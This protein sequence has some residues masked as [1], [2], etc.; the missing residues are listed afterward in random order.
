MIYLP[1]PEA[2]N[3]MDI[4]ERTLRTRIAK[5]EVRFRAEPCNGGRR[6]EVAVEDHLER[7]Y[8]GLNN[9]LKEQ[10]NEMDVFNR[11]PEYKKNVVLEWEM[12]FTMTAGFKGVELKSFCKAYTPKSP[13]VKLT[14]KTYYRK[15][16][17]YIKHGQSALIPG[18]GS[19]GSGKITAGQYEYFKKLYLKEMGPTA[20]KCRL[21]TFGKFGTLDTSLNLSTFPSASAFLSKLRK[22][23]KQPAI[24]YARR[25]ELYYKRN[26]EYYISRDWTDIEAGAWLVSDHHQLDVLCI[27]QYGNKIRPWLTAWMD[28]RTNK[29]V[30]SW[31]H[32]EAPNSD[33]IFMTFAWAVEADGLPDGVYL[34]NGKD[35]RSLD[36]SGNPKRYKYWEE[37]NEHHARCLYNKFKVK[38]LF[39]REYNAQAKPIEPRFK[40]VIAGF[41]KFLPG[42]TGS[43][44]VE[45]PE[46]LNKQIKQNKLM[47]FDKA[48]RL[49]NEYI[50]GIYNNMPSN[51]ELLK[52]LSP[53]QAYGKFQKKNVRKPS[54]NSMQLLYMRSKIT[55]IGR[56]GITDKSLG[57][58][59]VYWAD[60]FYAL[61]KQR[62][63]YQRDMRKYNVAYVHDADNGQFICC[64]NLVNRMPGIVG[65]VDKLALKEA[66][67]RKNRDLKLVRQRVKVDPVDVEEIMEYQRIAVLSMAKENDTETTTPRSETI[68]T[69]EF[70]TIRDVIKQKKIKADIDISEYAPDMPVK[71]ET[72]DIDV[73]GIRS[74]AKAG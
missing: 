52:G 65:D 42:Y 71:E 20:E 7:R 19:A 44:V 23:L 12:I 31:L 51:G 40:Q 15:H 30:S 22:S 5:N 46:G 13:H 60:D 47:S 8:L 6:Y 28:L 74:R 62:V 32:P 55:T 36:L 9:R 39:A 59:M 4:S 21:V 49:F 17:G 3:L 37:E 66:I 43:N 11:L 45:R 38:T 56:N 16:S 14:V 67:S 58:E 26:Y 35:Y 18:W 24:D 25:G 70:D 72:D 63:W 10:G 61:R 53:N 34:D 54:A 2:A 27:D 41:S 64:A 68:I 29:M 57:A 1:L 48:N 33:H 73:W 50:E 69:S